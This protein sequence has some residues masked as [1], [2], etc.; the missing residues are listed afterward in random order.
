MIYS[1]DLDGGFL[2]IW[3]TFDILSSE[4]TP[5]LF[6]AITFSLLAVYKHRFFCS[7]ESRV[8]FATTYEEAHVVDVI[9]TLYCTLKLLSLLVQGID[10]ETTFL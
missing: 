2:S 1:G 4:E 3:T 10:F 5:E 8:G 7:A 6:S 9:K